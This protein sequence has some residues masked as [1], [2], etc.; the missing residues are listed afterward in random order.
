MPCWAPIAS[1]QLGNLHREQWAH[2]LS[3]VAG[4]SSG[5]EDPY[6]LMVLMVVLLLLLMLMLMLLL[7]LMLMLMLLLMLMLMLLLKSKLTINL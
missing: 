7:M 3:I 4:D 5:E 6:V 2:T 1:A